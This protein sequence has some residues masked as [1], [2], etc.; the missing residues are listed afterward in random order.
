MKN[1]NVSENISLERVP[2]KRIFHL[3]FLEDWVVDIDLDVFQPGET[4][5]KSEDLVNMTIDLD[6]L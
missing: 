6:K 4:K 1:H 2:G 3:I 5:Q